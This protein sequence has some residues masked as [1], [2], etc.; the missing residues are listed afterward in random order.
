[1]VGSNSGKL[2]SKEGKPWRLP[3]GEVYGCVQQS[4]GA[5]KTPDIWICWVVWRTLIL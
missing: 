1:M 5:C 4:V 3:T 2:P